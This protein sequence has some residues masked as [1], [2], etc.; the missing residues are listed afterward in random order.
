MLPYS[1]T[2]KFSN[3]CIEHFVLLYCHLQGTK[4]AFQSNISQ[5]KAAVG[6]L[7][8]PSQGNAT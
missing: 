1:F 8:S 7:L 4:P 2:W 5:S 3:P 6:Q